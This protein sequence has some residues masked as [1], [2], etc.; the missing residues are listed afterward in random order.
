ML[1]Q[2]V[3]AVLIM[4]FLRMPSCWSESFRSRSRL[5]PLPDDGYF[6][7]FTHDWGIVTYNASETFRLRADY[8]DRRL[9]TDKVPPLTCE[10]KDCRS[11]CGSDEAGED[12]TEPCGI[13]PDQCPCCVRCDDSADTNP[14][15]GAFSKAWGAGGVSMEDK[16]LPEL[17]ASGSC[18][19]IEDRIAR[20]ELSIFG[21]GRT[22]R[23]SELCRKMALE[24]ICIFWGSQNAMY[25]NRCIGI[26]QSVEPPLQPCRSMCVQLAITCANNPDY[27]DLCASIP[28]GVEN[29]IISGVD[30]EPGFNYQEVNPFDECLVYEYGDLTAGLYNGAHSLMTRP[31][32]S[33]AIIISAL[34]IW[35]RG[36]YRMLQ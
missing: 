12:L 34:V 4:S 16:Y 20:L 30:C 35:Q 28:C 2:R 22:F 11:S 15:C 1:Q 19:N 23:D 33:P 26:Q 18:L 8:H 25:D 36:L 3:V 17:K 13:K 10:S 24:Y 6:D 27:K 29:G 14:R 9:A 5:E 21:Q 32:L 7:P 31:L